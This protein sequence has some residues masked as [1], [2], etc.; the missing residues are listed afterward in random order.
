MDRIRIVGGARLNGTIPISGAL[1]YLTNSAPPAIP[2][3]TY[4]DRCVVL[5]ASTPH[6][7]SNPDGTFELPAY[8]TGDAMLVVQKGAFRRVRKITVNGGA[9]P[10][11]HPYT[12]LPGKMDKAHGDDIP[13]MAV[14]QGAWDKIEAS[15]E[16]MPRADASN[17]TMI[18][19][20]SRQAEVAVNVVQIDG[21]NPAFQ[22]PLRQP[23]VG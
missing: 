6:V 14:I 3:K 23:P 2:T 19:P 5:D 20:Y 13:K 12:T 17:L 22:K 18:G 11:P 8:A 10:L 7:F 9:Q 1:V 15:L 16:Q 4:C 21:R